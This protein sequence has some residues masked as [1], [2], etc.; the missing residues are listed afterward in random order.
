MARTSGCRLLADHTVDR[1]LHPLIPFTRT[2]PLL[3][4]CGSAIPLRPLMTCTCRGR[5]RPPCTRVGCP[6]HPHCPTSTPRLTSPRPHH[7][8]TCPSPPSSGRTH[9][10]PLVL[11]AQQ[12]HRLRTGPRHRLVQWSSPRINHRPLLGRQP[13]HPLWAHQ[14]GPRPPFLARTGHQHSPSTH[15]HTLWRC[16]RWA[17]KPPQS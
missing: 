16:A 17:L 5:R 15:R 10:C 4:S 13:S 9:F 12:F 8:I 7:R 6:S 14:S 2:P 1:I 11:P 3:P